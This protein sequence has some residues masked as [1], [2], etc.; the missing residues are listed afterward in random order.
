[1]YK[2][3]SSDTTRSSNIGLALGL[4]PNRIG[5]I[6]RKHGS[7]GE[8]CAIAVINTWLKQDYNKGGRPYILDR[9]VKFPTWWSFV[10]A[11]ADPVGGN[12][13]ALAHDLAQN[14]KGK[15]IL[16][17]DMYQHLIHDGQINSS[18]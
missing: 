10:W 4:H 13:A 16:Q 18:L 8:R 17:I 3:I 15:E 14:G 9:N 2:A 1:M 11:V 7:G 5:L 6:T 12:N